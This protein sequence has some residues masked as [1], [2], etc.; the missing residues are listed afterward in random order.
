MALSRYAVIDHYTLEELRREYQK[1][2]AKGRVCLL[3]KLYEDDKVPPF[4]IALLA[5]EDPNV[6]VRQW[7]AKNGT[8]LD[9]SNDEPGGQNLESRLKSDPDPF[10]RACLRENP[11]ILTLSS[12]SSDWFRGSNH[13]ER[14]ALMR[15][16]WVSSKLVEKI[17]DL[18]D[19]ELGISVE[20]RKEL[21]LA[22]LT[23]GDA[24]SRSRKLNVS[25]FID[26][27]DMVM[28]RG[29]FGQLWTLIS[30]WP[31][32]TGNLQDAVYRYIGATDD[33]KAEIYRTCEEPVWRRAIL[34]NCNEDDIQTL[35]LGMKDADEGCR[36]LA[37]EK[38]N[39]RE[40]MTRI[41]AKALL[42][43]GA[44]VS[45][46]ALAMQGAPAFVN[47]K[48]ES[49]IKSDDKSALSGLARNK[50]LSVDGLRKV[51]NRLSELNDDM[52]VWMAGKTIGE[53]EKTQAPVDA[54]ELFEEK[55]KFLEDKIDFVGRKILY[56][57]EQIR[58]GIK[59]LYILAAIWLA[60][61]F[62]WKFLVW[63]LS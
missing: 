23:N 8:Y 52:G 56:Y 36:E 17:F 46:R 57:E 61:Y 19:Q 53:L 51:R 13:M 35:E 3:E 47:E 27:L 37:Y 20:E 55:G 48:L 16:R 33:T 58:R 28:T 49:V 1:A 31:K 50:F 38:F 54:K 45:D 42:D 30:K 10:V 34:E 9:Y 29:H 5:V 39:A 41:M 63:L 22:Y 4:E 7:I 21:V 32:G 43:N 24:L 62:G 18:N 25:D 44:P 2:D 12:E 26:G 60:I 59:G 15:N 40:F 6:E 14:L 11:T